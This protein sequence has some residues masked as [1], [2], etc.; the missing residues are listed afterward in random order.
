MTKV[1][2]FC[3]RRYAYLCRN[4]TYI[5]KK[6][7]LSLYSFMKKI[8]NEKLTISATDPIRARSYDYPRFTYPWHF[9]SEYEILYV[10][11]GEGDCLVGDGIASYMSGDVLFFG[12]ELPHSMQ[13]PASYGEEPELRVRG[14]NVQFERDFMHYSIS[15]YSQFVPIRNL[16]ERAGRGLKY[17]GRSAEEI[18][19]LLKQIPSAKGAEQIILL[20]S[21]LQIMAT[22]GSETYLTTSPYIAAP[23]VLRNERMDKILHYLTTH[24]TAPIGLEQIASYTAMNPSAFCRYFKENTGKTLKE[25]ILEMRVTYA[26]KLLNSTAMNVSEISSLCGFDSVVHFNR[27]FKRVMGM[28]PTSYRMQME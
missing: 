22:V 19:R 20:L 24:Y 12:S 18:V 8:M 14:I 15:Q 10:E 25:Y 23:S 16:L 5:C 1:S 11:T 3:G 17:S 27:I 13:S 2:H 6:V 9:H 21:L 28:T 7:L 4:F 26:C